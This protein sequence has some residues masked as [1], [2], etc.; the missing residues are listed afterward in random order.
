MAVHLLDPY[1]VLILNDKYLRI[2]AID[3]TQPSTATIPGSDPQPNEFICELQLPTLVPKEPFDF[4]RHSSHHTPVSEHCDPPTPK[5][6]FDQDPTQDVVAAMY[7]SGRGP[8]FSFHLLVV[9][10]TSLLAISRRVRARRLHKVHET[11]T[12]TIPWEDWGLGPA[13]A[14]WLNI[15][16]SGRLTRLSTIG[17]RVV[18]GSARNEDT[19]RG[20]EPT[21]TVNLLILDVRPYVRLRGASVR[22]QSQV[23]ETLLSALHGNE[24][25]GSE[26][27]TDKAPMI[28]V[29]SD[30]PPTLE[31]VRTSVPYRVT[32]RRF[33]LP[34]C[35]EVDAGL[36]GDALLFFVRHSYRICIVVLEYLT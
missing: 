25:P 15:S 24:G 14:C 32:Q 5:P 8:H 7:S 26:A 34:A 35:S 19:A 6:V 17:S 9:P 18:V 28:Q 22:P 21:L 10:I 30:A 31:P 11:Q 23:A 16:M 36:V 2:Y 20:E 1:H 29:V 13:G 12:A 33:I 27:A 3:P 4:I